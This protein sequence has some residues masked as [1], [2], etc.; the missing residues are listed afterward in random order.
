[1]EVSAG[2]SLKDVT[3]KNQWPVA[4]G[5]EEGTCGTCMI[6]IVDGKENLSPM[7]GK[8]KLTLSAMGMDTSQY[9]LCCQCKINGDCTFEQ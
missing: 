4:Y 3:K 7:E 2:S 6:K 5:C 1:V 9:R 8:E